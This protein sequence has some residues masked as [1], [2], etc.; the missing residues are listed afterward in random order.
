ML[1][2]G[3]I[4][5]AGGVFFFLVLLG[6]FFYLLQP[7]SDAAEPREKNFTVS[8]GTG[9]KEIAAHLYSLGLI[10]SED[11]FKI[12][13]LISGKAGQLKPGKYDLNVNM[14]VPL[15]VKI[16]TAGP[17]EIS[18]TIVPGATLRE[19][20]DKLTALGII[21][22]GALTNFDFKPLKENYNFLDKAI[23][24]EGFLLADTYYFLPDSEI[25]VVIQKI[26][27]NFKQKALVLIS[28]ENPQSGLTNNSDLLEL[29]NLASLLE[30]E[31]PFSEEQRVVAGIL[32]KRLKVGMPLQVD[33]TIVYV[34]CS[35]RFL[36]CPPLQ[37][38]NFKI[39]SAYNTYLYPGLPPTPISNPG[40]DAIKAALSPIKS[41]Y[42]YYLSDPET[43]KTIFSKTI[44]E[45]NRN[46]VKYLLNK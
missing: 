22:K 38:E 31:V 8:P 45:H 13:A 12:Y 6:Y 44:D 16:L 27:D 19:I 33:A 17:Q 20:D 25:E 2:K 26:L 10:R 9:L 18:V 40:L 15:I 29:L 3:R 41:D 23:S 30:K 11:A 46:R 37:K 21:K 34:K 7:V 24:L 42:W 43:K 4:F 1:M 5:M 39:E 35:G 32:E 14:A 28:P 36:N